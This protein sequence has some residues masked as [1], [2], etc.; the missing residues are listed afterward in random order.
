MTPAENVKRLIESLHDRTSAEMDES[1]LGDVL[2]AL[3][4]SNKTQSAASEPDIRRTIMKS[5]ITK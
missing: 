5:P 2:Q 3:D 1:V 4:E